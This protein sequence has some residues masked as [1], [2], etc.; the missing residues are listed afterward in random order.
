MPLDQ[1]G[2]EGG[3]RLPVALEGS[4]KG[5]RTVDRGKTTHLPTTIVCLLGVFAPHEK[6]ILSGANALG[7]NT[8]VMRA[9]EDDMIDYAD[10]EEVAMYASRK[11]AIPPRIRTWYGIDDQHQDARELAWKYSME[12]DNSLDWLTARVILEMK[13]RMRKYENV[14]TKYGDGEQVG[15]IAADLAMENV[16]TNDEPEIT[17]FEM[18]NDME[19][20]F[21]KMRWNKRENKDKTMRVLRL[22]FLY[23]WGTQEIAHEMELTHQN[24]SKV[25]LRHSDLIKQFLPE[26]WVSREHA[27]HASSLAR[28]LRSTRCTWADMEPQ[29]HA[30]YEKECTG[31]AKH[32]PTTEHDIRGH[33]VWLSMG[34]EWQRTR[35]WNVEHGNH[36]DQ[37]RGAYPRCPESCT[38]PQGKVKDLSGYV[39]PLL[40]KNEERRRVEEERMSKL[41]C[42]GSYKTNDRY[43]QMWEKKNV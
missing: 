23:R 26:R 40:S 36:S 22:Y 6:Y 41:T 5:G 9:L 17:Q 19:T 28:Y 16:S 33:Q 18:W 13:N 34:P 21:D 25:I 20:C 3:S 2:H 38:L 15:G 32:I 24:V 37:E 30:L 31:E 12:C 8:I 4:P 10:I 27:L 14:D 11:I 35:L 42:H 1:R 7:K 39:Q 43:Y 29:V